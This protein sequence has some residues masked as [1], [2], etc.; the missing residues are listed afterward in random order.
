MDR[1]QREVRQDD[2]RTDKTGLD[3]TVDRHKDVLLVIG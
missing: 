1:Q 2:K 3:R